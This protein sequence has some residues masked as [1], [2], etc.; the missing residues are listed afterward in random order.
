MWNERAV[1]A[2]RVELQGVIWQNQ[3]D[4]GDY[5]QNPWLIGRFAIWGDGAD[6]CPLWAQKRTLTQALFDSI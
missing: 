6:S 3:Q 5:E 2:M 1:R 4:R